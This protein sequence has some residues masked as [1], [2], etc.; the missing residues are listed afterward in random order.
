MRSCCGAVVAL[1][2]A[3]V[4]CTSRTPDPAAPSASTYL[5][6]WTAAADKAQPDFLAVLDVTER[7][8]RYGRLVTTL[9]VP[10][11]ENVPHHTEH[12]MPADKQ[13]FA[14]GFGTGQTFVFDLA[15]ATHPR[16][17]HQFGDLDGYSHPH[18]FLRLP[19][20]NVLA[21]FQMRHGAGGMTPGGLVELTPAGVPVRSSSADGPGVDPELRVYSGAIVASLDRVVTTTTDMDKDFKASRNLQVWRLSDLKLLSTFPLPDGA[22][23]DEGLLTAEPRLLGD[24]RTVLVSTFNCGLYLMQGLEGDAPS[25]RLVASFPKKKGTNCAIPVIA[26]KYYLVTVPAWSAV[27]SLDI[28]DPARPREVSRVTLGPD[29]VPHWISLSPDQRRVVV[30]GYE[31]MQH[32]V[33]IARFDPATGALAWDER[34][35]EE[36][37]TTPG[38]RMDDKTW[39]HGGNAKGIP[40]GAVFSRP[41]ASN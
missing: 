7:G 23:G 27:V 24:G 17:T 19:N 8:D 31:G 14:N 37:A 28:S 21:T 5:Y 18:S 41:V 39:P 12:E 38:F 4:G 34:F 35:R 29:D 1:L 25:A 6:L 36:G 20:G 22:A 32:R 9:P 30:T 10:G 26:G 13:L 2:V 40:H 15:D 16:I 33:V 3:L 11:R